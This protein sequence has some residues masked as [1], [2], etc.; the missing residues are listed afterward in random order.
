MVK[1][2]FSRCLIELDG[3]NA[4]PDAWLLIIWRVIDTVLS[5]GVWHVAWHLIAMVAHIALLRDAAFW[6]YT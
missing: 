4:I 6:H 1:V 2:D 5:I 3:T